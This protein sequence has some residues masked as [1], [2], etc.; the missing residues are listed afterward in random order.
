MALGEFD[1]I[2]RYFTPAAY[3]TDVLLGVGDDAAVLEVPAGY[4]LVAA[5]DT[6]VEG[7]HFPANTR[8]ADIAYRALA[9]NLSDM[10]AM[11][12]QPRWFTLSLCIPQAEVPWLDEFAGSLRQLAQHHDVQLV[13]GD[14][15]KGPM[16]IS[17]Q[18]LGL[19]EADGW[20]T[21]SGA[22]PGDVLF[23]SGVPGEAAG[24]LQLLQTSLSVSEPHRRHLLERF[25]RP[26]P[27]VALG[28]CIRKLASAAMDVSD[29]LL[30]DLRKLCTA[31]GCGAHLDLEALPHSQALTAVFGEQTAERHALSGGDDYELLFTVPGDRLLQL[32]AAIAGLPVRCT[33]IGRIV[34]GAAMQCFRQGELAVM[35]GEGFDHFAAHE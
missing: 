33:P 15:V 7:I 12:A 20:L 21:R 30:T 5:V 9:V 31:S 1:L 35:P 32:E 4:K 3:S 6:I 10:A 14:T 18:I 24:G 8:A 2:K 13:G 25:Y 19:V 26:T 34:E 27:R 17:V 11:G 28:R 29:G 16:N 23:V 22:R